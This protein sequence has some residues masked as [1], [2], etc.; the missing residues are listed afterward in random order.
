MNNLNIM[1][2]KSRSYTKLCN[3]Y[4]FVIKILSKINTILKH[5]LNLNLVDRVN[6]Q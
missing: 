2:I 1:R 3:S 4:F 5:S 6:E